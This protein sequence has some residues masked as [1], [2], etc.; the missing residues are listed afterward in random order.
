MRKDSEDLL[1]LVLAAVM[2]ADADDVGVM[3]HLRH[4]VPDVRV[5]ALIRALLSADQVIHE[6]FNGNAA[7]R[8]DAIRARR[9]AVMLT[10]AADEV[11]VA[12]SQDRPALRLVDLPV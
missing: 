12:L 7:G 1:E 5:L 3:A 2:A 6:T 10:E 8:K 11:D 4:A 9:L